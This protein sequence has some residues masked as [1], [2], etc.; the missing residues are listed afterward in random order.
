MIDFLIP[1]LNSAKRCCI[2]EYSIE[3]RP[4]SNGEKS[5]KS[6][7]YLNFFSSNISLLKWLWKRAFVFKLL[8]ILQL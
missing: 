2:D 4:L 5:I 7:D 8:Q 6:I 3:N 1:L